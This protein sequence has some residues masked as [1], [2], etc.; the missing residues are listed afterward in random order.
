MLSL[1][2]TLYLTFQETAAL[3]SK[4]AAPFYIPT[5]MYVDC[6]SLHLGFPRA[7]AGVSCPPWW[8]GPGQAPHRGCRPQRLL[9]PQGSLLPQAFHCLPLYC[10]LLGAQLT[11][12]SCLGKCQKSSPD[13]RRQPF[14]GKSFYLDLPAGKNLQFL[15][16]AIQQLGGVGNLLLPCGAMCLHGFKGRSWR[17][18]LPVT[19]RYFQ[20]YHC[21]FQSSLNVNHFLKVKIIFFFLIR[22]VIS[23]HSRNLEN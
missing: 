20:G 11:V 18:V 15:T 14:S 19:S 21:I 13:A 23:V 7:G 6:V 17:R 5:S 2:L 3:L 12:S 16:G 9:D 10:C 1:M 22:K 4:V 8:P